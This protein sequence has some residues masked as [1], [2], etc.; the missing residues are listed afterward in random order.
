MVPGRV[1]SRVRGF[2]GLDEVPL[3]SALGAV[4]AL[5]SVPPAWFFEGWSLSL[6]I[7]ARKAVG[8]PS[9]SNASVRWRLYRPELSTTFTD[10][11]LARQ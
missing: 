11:L 5:C 10:I 9:S 4:A 3:T 2:R 8:F 6:L 1:G 7:C